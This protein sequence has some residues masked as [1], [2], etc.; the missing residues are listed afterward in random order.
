[1]LCRDSSAGSVVSHWGK[2]KK[3]SL[4]CS[5]CVCPTDVPRFFGFKQFLSSALSADLLVDAPLVLA[6]IPRHAHLRYLRQT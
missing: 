3:D 5:T 2:S 4:A 1:M 6:V